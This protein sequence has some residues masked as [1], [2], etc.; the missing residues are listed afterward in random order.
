M[1]VLRYFRHLDAVA[2]A[3]SIRRAADQLYIT[4]SSLDRQIQ[5]MEAE[6]ETALFERQ[7]RGVV[8][9]AAGEILLAY[10]R[11]QLAD[12]ERV[13]SQISALQALQHGHV[14]IVASQA[15]AVDFLP[16]VVAGFR[17]RYPGITFQIRIGNHDSAAHALRAYEAD[18][19][20]VI[21]L[22][23]DT[24]LAV[25]AVNEEPVMA[26]MAAQHPLA[27]ADRLRMSQCLAYP[28]VL[29]ETGL[30]TRALI[31]RVLGHRRG[32][33]VVA[34]E[35]NSFELMRGLLLN[36]NSIGFQVAIGVPE[37]DG[38]EQLIARPLAGGEATSAPL[39]CAQLRGRH[40]S[41]AA[42][43]FADYLAE[44]LAHRE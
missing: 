24:N 34:A 38:T 4:P 15:L 25:L 22:P 42:A 29:P 41:V 14:R 10:I 3:G 23:T 36:G 37:S 21:S 26:M 7:P 35:T 9:T 12:M 17:T 6:F 1:R 11:R 43:R 16:R 28:L 32:D 44:R 33:A 39:V 19:A 18:L 40:L 27:D 2:R 20:L 8:P 13:Q 30:G 31:D 5:S